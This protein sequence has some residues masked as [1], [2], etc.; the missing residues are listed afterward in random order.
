MTDWAATIGR[1]RRWTEFVAW[2][3]AAALVAL[4]LAATAAFALW[5]DRSRG[6][7][8]EGVL[9]LDLPPLPAAVAVSDVPEPSPDIPMAEAP[10]APEPTEDPEETPPLPEPVAEPPPDLTE[11]E[12]IEAPEEL[13]ETLPD[14]T[15]PEPPPP[16]API[17]EAQ[18]ALPDT[19]RPQPR[20]EPEPERQERPR[21]QQAQRQDRP[22]EDR[23]QPPQSQASRASS[24]GAAQAA[25]GQQATA[26]QME[27]WMGKVQGQFQRHVGRRSFANARPLVLNVTVS[28]S[29]QV[30]RATIAR[31]SGDPQFDAALLAHFLRIGNVA[32]PPNG[33][34]AN[35]IA[36]LAPR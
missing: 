7:E 31:S 21:E 13:A 17:V 34:S 20:R 14:T 29:G 28:G 11:P 33:Q 35:F 23:R 8:D 12:P 3:L 25:A 30:T 6:Q 9:M 1:A 10:D 36:P 19:P 27:R 4:M 5:L 15:S 16:P 18:V 32:A 24:G 2:L 22:R 26:S